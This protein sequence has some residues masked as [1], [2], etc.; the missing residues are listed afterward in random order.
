[1]EWNSVK[2]RLPKECTDYLCIRENG[3]FEVCTYYPMPIE[4]WGTGSQ[5]E[6]THWMPLPKPPQGA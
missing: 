5:K 4:K 6:I 2:D 1:M 3:H